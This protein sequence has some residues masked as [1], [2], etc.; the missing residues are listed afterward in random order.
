MCRDLETRKEPM[1]GGKRGCGGGGQR[2]DEIICV[3]KVKGGSL[4]AEMLKGGQG[5]EERVS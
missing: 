3:L 2:G 5:Q 4:R 1:R